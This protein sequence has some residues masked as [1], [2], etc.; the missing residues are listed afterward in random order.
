VIREDLQVWAARFAGS[1]S[2]DRGAMSCKG[3]ELSAAADALRA[4][5]TAGLD[6]SAVG[7][8]DE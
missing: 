3:P 6:S 4:P 1:A 8:C 7:G 5:L 2:T